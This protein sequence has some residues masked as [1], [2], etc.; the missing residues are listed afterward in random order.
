MRASEPIVVNV[1]LGARS[2]AIVIGRGQ[3]ASLGQRIAELRPARKGCD[4][5]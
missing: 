3:I 2:Y 5:H 4:R 1:A